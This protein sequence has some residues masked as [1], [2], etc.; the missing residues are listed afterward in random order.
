MKLMKKM[1]ATY[2]L[3]GLA[4][5]KKCN[6]KCKQDL[7]PDTLPPQL[8]VDTAKKYRYQAYADASLLETKEGPYIVGLGGFIQEG[9]G[10]VI[11]HFAIRKEVP[12]GT[13][14]THAE[15]LASLA[16]AKLT[17]HKRL[18]DV[19]LLADNNAVPNQIDGLWSTKGLMISIIREKT[20]LIL[21]RI[22]HGYLWTSRVYNGVAD[23]LAKDAIEGRVT[24]H[25]FG[26]DAE[27]DEILAWAGQGFE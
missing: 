8:A 23:Q 19:A 18:Q 26:I 9:E 11:A 3:V 15:H 6:P 7:T 12:R 5:Y 25:D 14:P 27:I 17:M 21:A 10:N 2:A 22:G 4:E 16:L 1:A 24:Q 20:H 13:S